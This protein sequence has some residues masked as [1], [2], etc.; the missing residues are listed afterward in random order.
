MSFPNVLIT[1]HQGF[2]T[3]EALKAIALVTLENAKMLDEGMEL[4]NEV[5]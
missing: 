4:V 1:S 3:K 2:F 5:L